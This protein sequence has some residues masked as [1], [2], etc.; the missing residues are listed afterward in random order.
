MPFILRRLFKTS[1]KVTWK[2]YQ[3]FPG[4]LRRSRPS[5]DFAQEGGGGGNIMWY[6]TNVNQR[7]GNKLLSSVSH[8]LLCPVYLH[9]PS[10]QMP[11]SNAVIL[12]LL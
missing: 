12:L 6:S 2:S 11:F 10:R 8:V 1:Q 7:K 5:T 3:R 9:T 4:L